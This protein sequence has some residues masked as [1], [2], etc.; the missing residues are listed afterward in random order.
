MSVKYNADTKSYVENPRVLK[1]TDS[2]T[3]VVYE[4]KI[5]DGNITINPV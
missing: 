1:L 5:V 3:G 2:S 4:L